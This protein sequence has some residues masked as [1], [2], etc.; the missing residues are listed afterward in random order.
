MS[1]KII[2]SGD[3]DLPKIKWSEVA[4]LPSGDSEAFFCDVLYLII[5][6][7][8][9]I[10]YPSTQYNQII[11]I[12]RIFTLF[13]DHNCVLFDYTDK[14]MICQKYKQAVYDYKPSMDK[15]L[16]SLQFDCMTH[17]SISDINDD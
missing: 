12:S 4:V 14:S 7:P 5:I 11:I 9:G 3:F 2:V 13:S 6:I 16:G 1:K 8:P 15:V 17:D 10:T